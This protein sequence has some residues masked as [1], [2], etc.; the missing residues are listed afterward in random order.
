[1]RVN[2]RIA[3]KLPREGKLPPRPQDIGPSYYITYQSTRADPDKMDG[4]SKDG[5]SMVER[6]TGRAQDTLYRRGRLGIFTYASQ[7]T[8]DNIAI[9][10]IGTNEPEVSYCGGD[11]VGTC[12]GEMYSAS[13]QNDEYIGGCPIESKHMYASKFCDDKTSCSHCTQF[14]T[15]AECEAHCTELGPA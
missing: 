10:P 1:M 11:G 6:V 13:T 14:D 12:S 5:G 3:G 9:T 2:C 4:M 8:V 15:L 7:L